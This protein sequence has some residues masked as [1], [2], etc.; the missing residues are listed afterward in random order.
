MPPPKTPAHR[1]PP[2][3][4]NT[5]Q[6]SRGGATFAHNVTPMVPTVKARQRHVVRTWMSSDYPLS[7]GEPRQASWYQSNFQECVEAFGLL[8]FD[9]SRVN[10][11]KMISNH[12]DECASEKILCKFSLS[13]VG[14]NKIKY[15]AFASNDGLVKHNQML[16]HRNTKKKLEEQA[17]ENSRYKKLTSRLAA[18]QSR[19]KEGGR[20][21][22]DDKAKLIVHEIAQQGGSMGRVPYLMALNMHYLA[23]VLDWEDT[24]TPQT[25]Q[26]LCPSRE[27]V[28]DSA[29]LVG[30]LN[31]YNTSLILSSSKWC[32]ISIDEGKKHGHPSSPLTISALVP[33]EEEKETVEE[34]EREREKE[35][36]KEKAT[37]KDEEERPKFKP[38]HH[39]LCALEVGKGGEVNADFVR[40]AVTAAAVAPSKVAAVCV[41]GAGE[42]TKMF[43]FLC[44]YYL[45]AMHVMCALHTMSLVLSVSFYSGFGK[46][47]KDWS[48]PTAA[49][50]LYMIPYC[51]AAFSIELEDFGRANNIVFISAEAS[52]AKW[53]SVVFVMGG[54]VRGRQHLVTFLRLVGK[55][56]RSGTFSKIARD[57]AAWMDNSE[58]WCQIALLYCFTTFWWNEHMAWMQEAASWQDGLEYHEKKGSFRC[59]EM[60]LHVIRMGMELE[61][62]K[63]KMNAVESIEFKLWRSA[64]A[65]LPTDEKRQQL[66]Q[67]GLVMFSTAQEVLERRFEPY[68]LSL[69]D[70]S[71]ADPDRVFAFYMMKTL[72]KCIAEGPKGDDVDALNIDES[73]KCG[74]ESMNTMVA[75]ATVL[76]RDK[77]YSGMLLAHSTVL[78]NP[79]M[80]EAVKCWVEDHEGSAEYFASNEVLQSAMEM[81]NSMRMTTHVDEKNVAASGVTQGGRKNEG[82]TNAVV[83]SNSVVHRVTNMLPERRESQFQKQMET[84]LKGMSERGNEE[85]EE[86]IA[87]LRKG[88][89][90][91]PEMR[92]KSVISLLLHNFNDRLKKMT[93]DTFK[94]GAEALSSKNMAAKIDPASLVAQ[95]KA[96]KLAA[97]NKN[98]ANT[99]DAAYDLSS[100]SLYVR[101]PQNTTGNLNLLGVLGEKR[102]KDVLGMDVSKAMLAGE[103][104]ARNISVKK[105]IKGKNEGKVTESLASLAEKL[106]AYH[107]GETI[108]KRLTDTE[109]NKKRQKWDV[110]FQ[111]G[112]EEEAVESGEENAEDAMEVEEDVEKE[113]DAEEEVGEKEDMEAD[114]SDE[115]GS[116]AGAE[117]GAVSGRRVRR[118]TLKVSV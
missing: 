113:E 17:A 96:N 15:Y 4:S 51:L 53:W 97:N 86:E 108:I 16:I 54:M 57:V 46:E 89:G 85:V 95:T 92:G 61:E 101:Q 100:K 104:A 25:I 70:C 110:L 118:R 58:L 72:L 24:L 90:E 3:S 111:G 11:S 105:T 22:L 41:D 116:K 60:T 84:I 8:D 114:G 55:T 2:S 82:K 6:T 35:K 115:V 34:K 78:S 47:N 59:G 103:C 93:N 29:F 80:Y 94:A 87:L 36:E 75:R 77:K 32:S 66:R 65:E 48:I 30:K 37:A 112:T 20:L 1:R 39:L 27:V 45:S 98:W 13:H 107:G 71:L 63:G 18:L 49:R 109:G 21:R 28:Q 19:S 68:L 38:Q 67:Q 88:K 117:G 50:L 69:I 106:K 64:L 5:P 56:N 42:M 40:K 14:A 81:I 73:I 74:K 76:V 33:A 9:A 99:S 26:A 12:I 7:D 102:S 91:K 83:K 23:V 62:L 10:V 31:A 43:A 52:F 79:V 44:V